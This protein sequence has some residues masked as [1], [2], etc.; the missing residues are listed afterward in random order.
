MM[1]H[2][3]KS[4]TSLTETMNYLFRDSETCVFK[5][6]SILDF[7]AWPRH[8]MLKLQEKNQL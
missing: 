7:L 1:T 8:D 4:V 5:H 6:N 2:Y 3:E